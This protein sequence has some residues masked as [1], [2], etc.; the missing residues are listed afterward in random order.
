MMLAYFV[1][2]VFG[3]ALGMILAMVILMGLLL[4]SKVQK[5]YFQYMQKL[6]DKATDEIK[7]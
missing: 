2:I 1:A 5:W 6:A 3:V 7:F 4:N